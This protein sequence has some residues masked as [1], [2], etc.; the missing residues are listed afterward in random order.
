M[1]ACERLTKTEM[2]DFLKRLREFN[3]AGGIVD[4]PQL[5][6]K[7]ASCMQDYFELL[8]LLV[9]VPEQMKELTALA[10]SLS[11]EWIRN[12]AVKCGQTCS[13][14]LQAMQEILK[15]RQEFDGVELLILLL[16][17]GFIRAR[18]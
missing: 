1:A 6:K 7:L 3:D 11:P 17:N 9:S 15:A 14:D 4:G 12:F 10:E 13:A 5:P 18:N 16:D 2:K 8:R